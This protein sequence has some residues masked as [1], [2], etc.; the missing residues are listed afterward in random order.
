MTTININIY[1]IMILIISNA[2]AM[3]FQIRFGIL[4]PLVFLLPVESGER[5][6]LS[7]TIMLSYAIFLTLVS[8]AIPSSSNPMSILLAVM[9]GIISISGLI[10]VAVILISIIYYRDESKE[11]N[12]LWTFIG[13]SFKCKK[14]KVVHSMI[15][16]KELPEDSEYQI[17]SLAILPLQCNIMTPF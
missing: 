15:S 6:G 17:V 8:A 14:K 1:D 12:T 16:E 4:N 7:M 13:K 11:L 3:S 10:V 5:I 2:L 9:M